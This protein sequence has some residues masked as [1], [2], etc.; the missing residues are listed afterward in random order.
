MQ[1]DTAYD[2]FSLLTG[3]LVGPLV[4]FWL[5]RHLG[6]AEPAARTARPAAAAG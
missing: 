5:G 4:A 3:A 1:A 2:V 6:E